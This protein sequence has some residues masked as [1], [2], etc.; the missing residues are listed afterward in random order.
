M[1]EI[2]EEQPNKFYG[3]I[4]NTNLNNGTKEI[5]SSTNQINNETKIESDKD[6]GI[7]EMIVGKSNNERRDSVDSLGSNESNLKI[8]SFIFSVGKVGLPGISLLFLFELFFFYMLL[9]KF[10]INVSFPRY[11][12]FNFCQ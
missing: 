2:I 11:H 5:N 6:I 4:D 7:C 1:S 12:T 10:N 9:E 8:T 3:T